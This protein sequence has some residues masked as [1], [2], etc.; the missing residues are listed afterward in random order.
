MVSAVLRL[1]EQDGSILPPRPVTIIGP[2][3]THRG[4]CIEVATD[5]GDPIYCTPEELADA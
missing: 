4:G 2:C 1:L 5:Q 3:P